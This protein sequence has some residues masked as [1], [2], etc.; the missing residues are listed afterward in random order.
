[1]EDPN[2][3][4]FE[5]QVVHAGTEPDPLTGA[6]VPPIYQTSTFVFKNADHGAALFRGEEEG[7]IYSRIGNPTTDRLAYKMSI[8]ERGEDGLVCSSGLSATLCSVLAFVKGGEH[9][10]SDGVI[11]G[12]TFCQFS[13]ELANMGIETSFVDTSNLDEV[14]S[15]IRPNTKLIWTETPANPTLKIVNIKV[16]ANLA[17]SKNL[18][19]V[20]DN[21]FAT[22]ALQRP[23]ELGATMVVH[24]ATKYIGGHGDVVAGIIVG[25]KDD[26]K[27]ARDIRGHLGVNLGP[28]EAW[29]LLRGLKTLSLRMKKHS[30]NAMEIAKYL[31]KHPRVEVTRYPGLESD[32]GHVTAKKQMSDFGGMVTFDV[33]GGIKAGKKVMDNVKLCILAVSL[34]DCETLIEHPASMT[35]SSLTPEELVEANITEGMIRLSVGIESPKDLI[36]DLDYVL[37]LI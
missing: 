32:A 20:V 8:L 6:L 10:V 27:R 9:M 12:G 31:E 4:D 2:M 15:A 14:E 36:A 18:P 29:L 30:A 22:P 21:T 11:Y 19:L 34:G 16:L 5:T 33:K 25:N 28:F 17:K 1:M 37:G 26:I 35:H 13:N 7:Y 3:Y 23:L 24:S